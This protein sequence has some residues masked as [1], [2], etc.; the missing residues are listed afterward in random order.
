MRLAGHTP[1][2]VPHPRQRVFDCHFGVSSGCR[3]QSAARTS[4]HNTRLSSA[5]LNRR[6]RCN[7]AK[8]RPRALDYGWLKT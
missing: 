6:L 3:P 4:T 5:R 8:S 7:K 1:R 2:D